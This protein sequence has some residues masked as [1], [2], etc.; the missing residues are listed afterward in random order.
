MSQVIKKVKYECPECGYTT[1]FQ[2]EGLLITSID[3]EEFFVSN[4]MNFGHICEKCGSFINR[5]F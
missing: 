5:V 3:G 2:E 1:T 4:Q